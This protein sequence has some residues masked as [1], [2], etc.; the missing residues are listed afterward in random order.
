MRLTLTILAV[1]ISL[2][3]N[4][5]QYSGMTGLIHVPSAEMDS[6][7]DA[8]IGAHFLHKKFLPDAPY[9]TV[10]GE[11]Y[12][13][14][15]IYLSLTPFWWVEVGFTMTFEKG[16]P[17]GNELVN[18][19]KFGQKDRYFSLK[20]NPLREGKYYPAVAIGVQDCFSA[21]NN[22]HTG[23]FT[24]YYIT[25]TK[26]FVISRQVF[27]VTL[28]YRYYRS[29]FNRRWNGVV[30]GITY[31]PSFAKNWR[32]VVEWTGCD[33]NV[34]IDCLLWKHMLLQVSL[35]DWRYPSAG[36]CYKVNLF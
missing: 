28:A 10:N 20:F 22:K 36:I 2:M 35:Q 8:R 14:F 1:V 24:N 6:T 21:S 3:A 17:K 11:P 18:T 5:Q 27:G 31:R 23:L 13:A 32:A 33:V 4:A 9:L 29:S 26:T 16:T 7:G 19:D 30:G 34:G 15:D 25:M 12:N